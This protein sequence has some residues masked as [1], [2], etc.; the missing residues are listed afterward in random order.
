MVEE[1][2]RRK[3]ISSSTPGGGGERERERE[4]FGN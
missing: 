3:N 4:D 2:I 1:S